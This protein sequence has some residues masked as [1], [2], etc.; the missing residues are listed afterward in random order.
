MV[1]RLPLVLR[2]H[3]SRLAAAVLTIV[4]G[5]AITAIAASQIPLVLKAL[6]LLLVAASLVQSLRAHAL[7][8]GRSAAVAL[9]LRD[10]AELE[11]TYADGRH[12]VTKINAS[13]TVLHSLIALHLSG[14]KGRRYLFL[15]P[16]TLDAE[17]WRL[18]SVF[19]R[20]AKVLNINQTK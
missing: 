19:L 4:H 8:I 11:V 7:R 16:D 9:I 2:L 18:F 5:L 17:S 12:A 20:S 6:L 13:S 14:E 1:A 3:P 15:L 10:G